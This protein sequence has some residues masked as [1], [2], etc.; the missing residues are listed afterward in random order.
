M[1]LRMD[2]QVFNS[3]RFKLILGLVIIVLPILSFLIYNNFYSINLVRSQVAQSNGNLLKLYM[4]LIDKDLDNIDSY[5]FHFATQNTSLSRMEKPAE[6][7]MNLYNIA[8]YQLFRELFNNIQTSE[9]LDFYY[10]YST[11]NQDLLVVHN[12]NFLSELDTTLVTDEILGLIQDSSRSPNFTYKDWTSFQNKKGTYLT[13]MIK[14]GGIYVGA[15]VNYNRLMTPLD[16]LDLGE[17]GKSLIVNAKQEPLQYADFLRDQQIE[18]T[19]TPG[20]YKLTGNETK[21]LVIGEKS[22]KGNFSLLAV[23]PDHIILENLTYTQR[24]I[25]FLTGGTVLIVILSLIFM[26]RILLRPIN[27]LLNAMR[28]IR[29]GHIEARIEL[30]PTSNEFQLMN[31]TFNSMVSQIE[32]LKIDIYEEQLLSKKAELKH[33]QLQINPH[34]YL[35]SLNAFYYLSEDGNTEVIKDLSLSLIEYFRFMFRSSGHDFVKLGD[36]I[37]HVKNYLRI[38]EFRFSDNLNY[39]IDA[40]HRLLDYDVP[41]LIVQTFVENA[42]KHAVTLDYPSHIEISIQSSMEQLRIQIRDNGKGFPK[43]VIEQLKENRNLLNEKGEHVGIWNIK[44]RLWLL[45]K[46]RADIIFY[47]N[48]GAVIEIRLPIST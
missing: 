41:L 8:K 9:I 46:E 39:H 13:R 3:I 33:L 4:G 27:R 36:E 34:F 29:N 6:Q 14:V 1:A 30:A 16:S 24:M 45:Y 17:N 5:L 2:F 10:T 22:T 11:E 26:R 18:F 28:K 12:S 19:Y 7:D 21:Y 35:N 20:E 23:I 25:A 31:E 37:N 43:E 44:R 47:N 40:P 42:I 15:L 38:Q 32:K 48:G